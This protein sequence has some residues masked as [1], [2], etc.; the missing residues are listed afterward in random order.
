LEKKIQKPFFYAVP[1]TFISSPPN[2][3]SPQSHT[4][5]HH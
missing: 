4:H 3:I 1:K 2:P 5:T